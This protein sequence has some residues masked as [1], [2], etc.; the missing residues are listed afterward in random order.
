MDPLVYYLAFSRL[1]PV[2]F[3][4]W[5][6][7]VSTALPDMDFFLSSEELETPGSESQY[8]EQLVK[9]PS[10]M[11]VF[12]RPEYRPITRSD[13]GLPEDKRLY[14]C[15]QSLFKIHPDMDATFGEILSTDKDGLLV[16]LTGNEKHWDELLMAR[17]RKSIPE[18]AD[19][20]QI[21][22]RLN[23][24]EYIGLCNLASVVLDTFY[25]GGGNSSLEAFSVGAPIVTLPGSMLRGR[26]TYAQ[27][28]A[29]GLMDLIA[30]DVETYAK[31]ALEVA[32]NPDL[33]ESL[34]SKILDRSSVLYDN[35]KPVAEL[36][37]FIHQQVGR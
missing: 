17:F 7:P 31:K 34:R 37:D 10:L 29:M 21:L 32:L 6:H 1:A 9:F 27:Y 24:N 18:V 4:T 33:R 3:M 14:V 23:L 2:Q 8:S 20:I 35:P 5:G 13:L 25:F 19:R 16:F 11:T 28:R 15:P 30:H 22:R 12:E 36:R 26:I